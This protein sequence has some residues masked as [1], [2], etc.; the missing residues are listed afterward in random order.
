MS[1]VCLNVILP[2]GQ[3]KMA[4]P[5][6]CKKN[7]KTPKHVRIVLDL[8]PQAIHILNSNPAPHSL[9]HLGL[10]DHLSIY[11]DLRHRVCGHPLCYHIDISYMLS[12]IFTISI[13]FIS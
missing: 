6:N 11:D 9:D 1:Y 12:F 8:P 7:K 3:V 5:Q 4:P 10:E 13:F 2:P